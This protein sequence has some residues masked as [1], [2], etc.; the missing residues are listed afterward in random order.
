M[1]T[2][3]DVAGK[4]VRDVPAAP[5]VPSVAEHRGEAADRSEALQQRTR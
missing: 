5:G 3:H 2:L 4:E 1:S